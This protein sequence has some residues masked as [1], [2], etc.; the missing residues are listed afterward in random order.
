MTDPKTATSS[1]GS[2]VRVSNIEVEF[3]GGR[4][5]DERMKFTNAMARLTLGS[6]ER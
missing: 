5:G 1:G 4:V 3:A 6:E 2:D